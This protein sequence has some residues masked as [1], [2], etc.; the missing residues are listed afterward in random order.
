MP[1]RRKPTVQQK[2]VPAERTAEQLQAAIVELVDNV[3]TMMRKHPR[4]PFRLNMP[5]AFPALDES[6]NA[7]NKLCWALDKAR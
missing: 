5:H 3:E 7:Y 6:R 4:P 1:G 2:P